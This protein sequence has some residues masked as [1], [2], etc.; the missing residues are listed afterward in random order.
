MCQS[1]SNSLEKREREEEGATTGLRRSSREME[2]KDYKAMHSGSIQ[3][4]S[5]GDTVVSKH[6][7]LNDHKPGDVEIKI[8]GFRFQLDEKA[9]EKNY[10]HQQA[11]ARLK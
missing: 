9:K 6:M 8:P 11:N 1:L 7:T 2:R 10:S 3:L 5:V 4:L